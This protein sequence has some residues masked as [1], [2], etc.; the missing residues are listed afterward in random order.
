MLAFAEFL[1]VGVA[2]ALTGVSSVITT[3]LL[4]DV[5]SPRASG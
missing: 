1:P 5:A 3:L 4:R 2:I